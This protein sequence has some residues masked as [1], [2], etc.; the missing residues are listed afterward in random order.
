MEDFLE[1]G[2]K[3]LQLLLFGLISAIFLPIVYIAHYGVKPYEEWWD[4]IRKL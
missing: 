3:L 4:S 1:L 2:Q